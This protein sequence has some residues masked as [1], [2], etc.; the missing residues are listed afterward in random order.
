RGAS[1]PPRYRIRLSGFT[2]YNTDAESAA[3]FLENRFNRQ[4]IADA[5]QPNRPYYI[6]EPHDRTVTI[7]SINQIQ[8]QADAE[9]ARGGAPPGRGPEGFGAFG[10]RGAPPDASADPPQ[11]QTQQFKPILHPRPGDRRFVIEW[12][13]ELRDPDQRRSGEIVEPADTSDTGDPNGANPS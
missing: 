8:G 13:V 12:V 2:P 9:D 10:L 6:P 7:K 11:E 1:A 5:N 4:L 3:D